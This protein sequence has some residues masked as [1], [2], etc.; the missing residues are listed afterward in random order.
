MFL[1]EEVPFN[2][3][4]WSC[5]TK[6]EL[7]KQKKKKKKHSS[8]SFQSYLHTHCQ[9]EQTIL[10]ILAGPIVF[11]TQIGLTIP[12]LKGVITSFIATLCIACVIDSNPWCAWGTLFGTVNI[13]SCHIL[14]LHVICV[15]SLVIHLIILFCIHYEEQLVSIIFSRHSVY[16]LLCVFA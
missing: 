8:E 7:R 5:N 6:T 14:L 10:L 16:H 9:E 4:L 2:D 11:K 12:H 13:C 15:Y 3:T 1:E